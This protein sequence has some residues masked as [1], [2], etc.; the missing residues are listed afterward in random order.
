LYEPS[1]PLCPVIEVT[2]QPVAADPTQTD[3]RFT[4]DDCSGANDI[5]N[6]IRRKLAQESTAPTHTQLL[7]AQMRLQLTLGKAADELQLERTDLH[8]ANFKRV[9]Q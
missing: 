1:D 2:S 3:S 6:D 8:H 7:D 4:F 5:D 9:P